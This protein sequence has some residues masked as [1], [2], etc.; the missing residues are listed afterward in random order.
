MRIDEPL[1]LRQAARRRCASAA[2]EFRRDLPQTAPGARPGTHV[3][4]PSIL[5]D[6]DLALRD[7]RI[8]KGRVFETLTRTRKPSALSNAFRAP[9]GHRNVSGS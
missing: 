4:P 8:R 9:N 6:W 3:S 2:N 7:G 1:R 5:S